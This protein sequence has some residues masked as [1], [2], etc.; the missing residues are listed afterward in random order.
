MADTPESITVFAPARLHL[1]FVDLNGG[2]GRRFG[3]LGL[4][5][6][7]I[8]TRVRARVARG[9]SVSGEDAPRAQRHL[10]KLRRQLKLQ[11]PV[12]LTIEQS[13]Q[14]HSGLGSG[15][16]L[17]LAVGTAAAQLNG[18]DVS[19]RQI[20]DLL[21]RGNRS[22]IGLG[23]FEYG[24]FLVDGGRGSLPGAPPLISRLHFPDAWRVILLFDPHAQ[25]LHGTNEARAFRELAPF[26][27]ERA[28]ELAH[29]VLLRALPAVAEQDLATF[30]AAIN[31]IQQVIGDYFASAQGG[32]YISARV[33]EALTW[34]QSQG[35]QCAGQTSWGPTG[36]AI[37]ADEEQAK[38]LLK[39]G[40]RRL[41]GAGLDQ[42]IC[43]ARNRG[44]GV[45]PPAV[46][47][48]K[49]DAA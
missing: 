15:T 19:P 23:A 8:G 37:V 47:A 25:G 40:V 9:F 32:R 35:V 31:L 46:Q 41:R 24:G 17:A 28:G 2:H 18:L 13:L 29:A 33:G 38:E 30:G 22:G 14:P 1:G 42:R 27:Q 21:D 20:A 34:M 49:Q 5:L 39:S 11:R 26:P 45:E 48:P 43:R 6:D 36:F 10:A 3:S 4:A 44:G 16:Q 7:D 12:A